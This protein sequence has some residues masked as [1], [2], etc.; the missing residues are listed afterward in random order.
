MPLPIKNVLVCDAVDNACVKLLQDHGIN[1][2]Y[3]L[4]LTKAQL[5]EEVKGYDALIVRSD[6][7]ITAEILDA[8][9]G[10]LKA[11]GRAGAGVDN[12]DI[13]AATRNNVVVLNTPGGNSI[14]ACELT[15]FLIGALARPI[16]SAATSMKEGR[17]DR[18]LYSGSELHGKTLAILGLGRIGREVGFRMKAFG[19]R[20]IGFDPITTQEEAKA[21]GI[22]KM[23]LDDIWPLADYITVHTPLIPATRNLISATTLAK[24]R[25]GV[26]V[27]N[28][29]RGGI[30]DEAA[31]VDAL[32]SGQCG[33]AAV[34]VYP[35]EPPKSDT[36]KKLINHAKVV[37]TPH[38][39]ASTTEAQV[40]VAVEVAEQFIAL[41]GTSKVYTEYAGVVNRDVLNNVF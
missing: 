34:D 20:V 2:D 24:C 19:M 9:A 10:Q 28:V 35:E 11:V 38:L 17:W 39:G 13:E 31:L 4:K 16:C 26:R 8:G 29:A 23:E 30:V 14:A 41:T 40:R 32:E 1:V 5:V 22:E 21:A 33:G 12:I 3:K 27:V 6:T 37:A 7:K 25:A 36:T 15:C 18:K